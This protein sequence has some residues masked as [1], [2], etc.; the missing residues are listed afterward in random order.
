[1]QT[2][3]KT[4]TK[5]TSR[6]LFGRTFCNQIKRCQMIS[7]YFTLIFD[8]IVEDAREHLIVQKIIL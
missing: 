8:M 5:T 6:C 1:M 2:R 4:A 7:Y 3:D